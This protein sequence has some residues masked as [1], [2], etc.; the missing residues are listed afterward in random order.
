M[1]DRGT[2]C[3]LTAIAG[4]L[5]PYLLTLLTFLRHGIECEH[6]LLIP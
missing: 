1:K 4:E 5:F 2:G 3:C 6:P